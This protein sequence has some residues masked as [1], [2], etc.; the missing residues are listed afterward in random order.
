MQTINKSN[1]TFSS[2]SKRVA[3][4]REET[5]S[6]AASCYFMM[7]MTG[8]LHAPQRIANAAP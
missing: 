8:W 3:I 1:N 4:A 5:T 2:L 6:M 7:R